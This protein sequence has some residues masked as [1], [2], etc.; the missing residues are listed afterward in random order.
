MLDDLLLMPLND[1]NISQYFPTVT[2]SNLTPF[3]FFKQVFAMAAAEDATFEAPFVLSQFMTA[4][5]SAIYSFGFVL[6]SYI[7]L[8]RRDL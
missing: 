7:S 3:P 8:K 2:I 6:F 1:L 4:V 5:L